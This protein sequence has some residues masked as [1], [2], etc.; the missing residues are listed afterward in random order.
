MG[1]IDLSKGFGFSG[2][3][4]SV[5]AY[6]SKDGRQY[7]RSYK[8]PT[9]PKTIKQMEHRAKFGLVNRE[10][11]RLR[12]PIVLGHR[13]DPKAYRKMIGKAYREA[14]G[15]TYP[16][17]YIDY[18][19]VEIAS[20]N[21]QLPS[22]ISLEIDKDS[23][24]AHI[25]WTPELQYSDRPGMN[26]DHAYIVCLDTTKPDDVRCFMGSDRCKGESIV[27][28][29]E[30]WNVDTSHFWIFFVSRNSR[31]NSNSVYLNPEV[32]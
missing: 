12:T 14:I 20:G 21:L 26:R 16:D 4:G 31:S 13:S 6:V 2:K 29:S 27:T 28:L 32:I 5:I 10:L 7:F 23:K 9:D 17:L 3:M 30:D 25:R 1:K 19:K 22:D 18:S 15:G 24:T 11:S 8:K